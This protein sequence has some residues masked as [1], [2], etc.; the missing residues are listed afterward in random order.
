M[1]DD[2][3][4]CCESDGSV[5]VTLLATC[6]STLVTRRFRTPFPPSALPLTI[7]KHPHPHSS[8]PLLIPTP[9][10]PLSPTTSPS[11]PTSP[12]PLLSPQD[13]DDPVFKQLFTADWEATYGQSLAATLTATLQDYCD[14]VRVWLPDYFYCKFVKEVLQTT[15]GLYV[16]QLRRFGSSSTSAHYDSGIAAARKMLQDMETFQTFFEESGDVL[17]RGGLKPH[18]EGA[19]AVAEELEPIAN[20]AT[21]CSRDGDKVR[22]PVSC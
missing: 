22:R 3:W 7:P 9:C 19:S 1:I 12:H 2:S 8:H 16:M 4:T 5:L 20:L 6:H 14:D 18:G 21:V 13:L 10:L 15:V 11:H 17:R